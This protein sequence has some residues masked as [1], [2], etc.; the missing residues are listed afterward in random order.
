MR[1][2]VSDNRNLEVLFN[3]DDAPQDV[4]DNDDLLTE[5][6]DERYETIAKHIGYI[7]IHF[8]ALE[9][10]V[11]L[12]VSDLTFERLGDQDE[13]SAVFL[14]EMT[15]SQKASTL[16]KLYGLWIRFD[17]F[18]R[19]EDRL[20]GIGQRLTES[21]RRR[22]QYAHADWLHSESMKW[23]KIK[24]KVSRQRDRVFHQYR[25]FDDCDMAD[26]LAYIKQTSQL[27]DEFH[28]EVCQAMLR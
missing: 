25:S 5:D 20:N 4:L 18:R 9:D 7:V 17:D 28:E 12:I 24:T 23:V 11:T 10:L 2:P 14:S 3:S 15:F 16:M 19:Y 8:N 27:L 6:L 13:R 1:C 21:S 26:D 22:N